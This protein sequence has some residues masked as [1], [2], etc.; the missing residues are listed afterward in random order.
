MSQALHYALNRHVNTVV[1]NDPIDLQDRAAVAETLSRQ[2]KLIRDEFLELVNDGINANNATEV[3]DGLADII[4]TADGMYHRLSLEH[5]RTHLWGFDD[6]N[7]QEQILSIHDCLTSLENLGEYLDTA[8]V[9]QLQN[10]IKVLCD[11][12]LYGVYALA[13]KWDVDLEADQE[14]VY[15]S[16]MSKFDLDED[17]AADGIA[18]YAALEVKTEL[19][20]KELDGLTYY[21]IKCVENSTGTDGKVYRV[22]KFLKSVLFEEPVLTSF[23]DNHPLNEF[24]ATGPTFILPEPATA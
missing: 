9:S 24:I 18:K 17:T 6:V 22:G 10:T 19:F 20:P 4:V 1:G 7:W 8:P 12:I 13:A 23:T 11:G 21:V 2:T 5:P 15:Q 14:A 16:N 3:R